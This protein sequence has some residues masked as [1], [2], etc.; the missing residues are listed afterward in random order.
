MVEAWAARADVQIRRNAAGLVVVA[1]AEPQA[2]AGF[3]ITHGQIVEMDILA[4][5][6]RL[7]ELDLSGLGEE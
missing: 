3:T 7:R 6:D 5:P 1:G 2:V 4:D